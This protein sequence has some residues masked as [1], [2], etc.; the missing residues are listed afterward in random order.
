MKCDLCKHEAALASTFLCACCTE[1]V[2]RL[3]VVQQRMAG[4]EMAEDAR[5]TIPSVA[6]AG[7]R[8]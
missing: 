6:V 3:I 2:Q 1:M 8:Y 7:S 4:T 5:R